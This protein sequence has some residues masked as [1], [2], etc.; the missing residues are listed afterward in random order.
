MEEHLAMEPEIDILADGIIYEQVIP[1][2]LIVECIQDLLEGL[3]RAV[4]ILNVT[5]QS[6]CNN[7]HVLDLLLI[8]VL[9]SMKYEVILIAKSV[10]LSI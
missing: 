2:S 1:L 8:S 10:K 9:N 4:I 5:V 3:G 7:A 6:D